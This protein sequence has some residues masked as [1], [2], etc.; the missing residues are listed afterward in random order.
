MKKWLLRPLWAV[1]RFSGRALWATARAVGRVV[2]A[3]TWTPGKAFLVTVGVIGALVA[4]VA[5]FGG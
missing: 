1:L 5:L 2:K 3:L 4:F